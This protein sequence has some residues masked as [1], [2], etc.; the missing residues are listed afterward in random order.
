MRCCCFTSIRLLVWQYQVTATYAMRYSARNSF[1]CRLYDFFSAYTMHRMRPA[2]DS[3]MQESMYLFLSLY[4]AHVAN[5]C[6]SLRFINIIC[7]NGV[8]QRHQLPSANCFQ[9]LF[10]AFNNRNISYFEFVAFCDM[11]VS[12]D[13]HEH[14]LSVRVQKVQNILC[15]ALSSYQ[16]L[17]LCTFEK[18]NQRPTRRTVR[19][20]VCL[21]M[22]HL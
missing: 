15:A 20:C 3:H 14:Q 2:S 11:Q 13:F 5:A 22:Q 16:S 12:G 7:M 4:P 8:I 17:T 1:N 21:Y 10:F 6:L 18:R 9:Y 19:L